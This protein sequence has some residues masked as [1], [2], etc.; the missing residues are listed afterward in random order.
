MNSF[1]LY[2]PFVPGSILRC[3]SAACRIVG[4]FRQA[5]SFQLELVEELVQILSVE[6]Q[7]CTLA[8]GHKAWSPDFIEGAALDA[9]VVHCLLVGEAALQMVHTASRVDPSVPVHRLH[10][11]LRL[12][13]KPP[14]AQWWLVRTV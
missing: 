8:H 12:T 4:G 6:D 3:S 7:A 1:R 11:P 2:G 10:T 14:S 9:D 5:G 13:V